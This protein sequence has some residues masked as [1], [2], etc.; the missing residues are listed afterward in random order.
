MPPKKPEK[1][2]LRRLS[3][4]EVAHLKS[5]RSEFRGGS[6]DERLRIRKECTEFVLDS[7]S[8]PRE[9]AIA[10]EHFGAV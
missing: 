1:V 10:F 4:A 3:T 9:N 2:T 7:R 8:I 6:R 5:H